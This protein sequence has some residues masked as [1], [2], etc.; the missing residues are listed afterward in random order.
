[1]STVVAIPFGKD[2]KRLVVVSP[3]QS[4][5]SRAECDDILEATT[6]EQIW[7]SGDWD[8]LGLPKAT[9][10]VCV[11]LGKEDREALEEAIT[12]VQSFY[13]MMLAAPGYSEAPAI[14]V[15]GKKTYPGNL[16]HLE[17]PD[18]AFWVYDG[19]TV[20]SAQVKAS[21]LVK[22]SDLDKLQLQVDGGDWKPALDFVEIASRVIKVPAPPKP[23]A[24]PV[25]PKQAPLPP[26]PPK[27]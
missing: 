14:T 1:M 13:D 5:V 2:S 22:R 11:V 10:K 4:P 19:A 24:P 20:L 12:K 25:T 26:A 17:A 16:I 21:D 8:K 7:V 18:T 27:K 6:G 3:K 23:P 15:D 9:R